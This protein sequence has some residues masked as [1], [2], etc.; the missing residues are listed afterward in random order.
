MLSD[1]FVSA[2]LKYNSYTD[3][4]PAPIFRK[5][6]RAN[7]SDTAKLTIGATGFYDLFLNGEKITCGFLAPYISN[8]DEIIFYDE[9]DLSGR[10]ADGENVI[11]VM[12][13]NGFANPV[14]GQ[15]WQHD[16]DRSSAPSFALDF[17][18]DSFSFD[19]RDM[20]WSYSHILFDDLRCG[21]YCDMTREIKGWNLCGL[22]DSAWNA[23]TERCYSHAEKRVRICEPVRSVRTIKPVCFRKGDLRDYRIR[24]ELVN[25]L[26]NGK[27]IMGKT[28]TSGGYIFD[29]G[30]NVSGVPLLKIKGFAGQK[31]EMQFCEL[32]FEGFADYINVDVYPD[33]CCQKDVYICSGVGEEEYVPPFTYHGFRY[34]YIYGVLPEQVTDEL[35][36]TIVLHND[37]ERKAS[38]SC[39]DKISNQIF[40][41]CVR[42]DLSNILHI[43]TDCPHREKNGWTGDAAISAQHMMQSFALEN[44]Y[45]DWLACFRAAQDE[46]G[47]LPLIVP[48]GKDR[49]DFP[50]WDSAV[51]FLP[52]YAYIYSGNKN[53]IIEN[54]TAMIENFKFHLT[55]KDERGIIERGYGDWL[56]VDCP[57][58]AYASPL[59]F[60]CTAILL[61]ESRMLEV[62]FSAV[63]MTEIAEFVRNEGKV[64]RDAIRR[65]YNDNGIITAG[66]SEKYRRPTYRPCQTSQAL[67]LTFGILDNGEIENAINALVHFIKEKDCS[68]DCGFLGLR[69]IFRVL[70]EY[71]YSDLAYEMI[72]K[73]SY[74]SYAN[75]IY[76]G[77]TTV[78]E[79][80]VAPGERTGSHNHHFMADVSGWYLEYI[81]GIVVNPNKN[82]ADHVAIDPH[83]VS[84]LVQ[85]CA[86]YKTPNGAVKTEWTRNGAVIELAVTVQGDAKVS[87][88]DRL[89]CDNNVVIQKNGTFFEN[90]SLTGRCTSST[91]EEKL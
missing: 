49:F 28:P 12:L 17:V 83:F 57:A 68:F 87:F 77:E 16:K 13:G 51:V 50:V 38:F 24:D 47:R 14:G 26:Y 31:I 10:L 74:P 91:M 69:Y 15:I 19:A 5:S 64:L 89:I 66:K 41:A 2:G 62:M 54:A 72:T 71:G 55:N 45:A 79:R 88:S 43:V 67:A 11:A 82:D 27:T 33:G 4:V 37:F 36:T 21:V 42:S 81:A 44:V 46:L 59:G 70:S 1:N 29:F 84:S 3:P 35:L 78:W 76:R 53:I 61:E 56:P 58:A 86:E 7:S 48:S 18:C 60:C 6:F 30:E 52:Y 20:K 25:M 39:S 75:M 63:G 65:E 34:C 8:P 22:D 80:F 23:P 90:S 9:Y 32:M 73:P 40:A 85:A